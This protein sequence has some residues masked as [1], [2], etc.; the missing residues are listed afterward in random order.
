MSIY[1][2]PAVDRI[3]RHMT[4]PRLVAFK[5]RDCARMSFNVAHIVPGQAWELIELSRPDWESG[6]TVFRSEGD[7][8]PITRRMSCPRNDSK[9]IARLKSLRFRLIVDIH[10]TS[11]TSCRSNRRSR[12]MGRRADNKSSIS[13]QDMCRAVLLHRVLRLDSLKCGRG[14][15]IRSRLYR[16]SDLV[17]RQVTNPGGKAPSSWV[18]ELF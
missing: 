3:T 17:V 8:S 9:R 6:L 2:A 13:F 12:R 18:P 11:K 16:F 4:F 7:C 14:S 10:E 5:P 1:V 15:W